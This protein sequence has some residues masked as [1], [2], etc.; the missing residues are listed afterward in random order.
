MYYPAESVYRCPVPDCPQGR[1]GSGMRDSW[2][3][4]WHFAHGHRGHKVAVA[5]ECY[6]RCRLCG[7]QVSTAGT[8]AHEASATCVRA[9]AARRQYVMAAASHVALDRTFS[10]YGEVLKSVRQFKYLGRIVSY[11]DN[12]TPAIRRNIKK[13]RR[14]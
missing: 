10:A 5:G 14:Q 4:R 8:P 13:A 9:A 3:V 7:M 1:D 11:D 2:N 6:R 12:D